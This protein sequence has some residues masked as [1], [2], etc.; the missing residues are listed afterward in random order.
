MDNDN[1]NCTIEE[2]HTVQ[3]GLLKEFKRV[4]D[5][6]KINYYLA[7][8]SCLGAVR[9][10]NFIPWDHDADVFVYANDIKKLLGV[11]DQFADGYFL[12]GRETDPEFNYSI[13]RLRDSRT[14]CIEKCDKDLNINHGFCIDIYPLYFAPKNKFMLHI[15]IIR[16]YIYRI[17][18]AGREPINHGAILKL[19]SNFVL[20]FYRGKRREKKI[21]S[22][23]KKLMKYQYTDKVLTYFGLDITPKSAITYETE[24]FKKPT[25]LQFADG[26]FKAPSNPKAY[27]TMKYGDY[28]KLPPEHERTPK[29]DELEYADVKVAYE[30]FK[31][32][33]YKK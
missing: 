23:R 22:C 13:Y 31:G 3:L 4:C 11:K 20:L 1:I 7:C 12:Q 9:N 32:V 21:A 24:W 2:I 27:L 19:C 17:C 18:I 10:K 29:F 33:Y 26:E 30:K 6:N 15:N 16:S 5:A 28:M 14:T 8:G 25:I